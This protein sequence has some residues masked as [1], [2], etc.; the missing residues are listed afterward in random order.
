MTC[1]VLKFPRSERLG[2][3]TKVAQKARLGV[4]E[5]RGRVPPNVFR[6][7]AK[8]RRESKKNDLISGYVTDPNMLAWHALYSA[9][10]PQ[11]KTQAS[12]IL[13]VLSQGKLSF[14][15]HP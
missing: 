12:G 4:L 6:I 13:K 15:P 1:T 8:K 14:D 11:Q 2:Q 9:L 5:L 7:D 3:K 10:T